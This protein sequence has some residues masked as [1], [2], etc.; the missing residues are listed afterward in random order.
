HTSAAEESHQSLDNSAA[1]APAQSNDHAAANDQGPA[2]DAPAAGPVAPAVAMV[3]AE[4]LQAAGLDGNAQ[5][6]GAVEK[7]V[8]EALGQG[9]GHGAAIDAILD[10]FHGGN[11]GGQAIANLASG[12]AN[13]VSAWD[14]AS[15]GGSSG[16]SEMLM[17]VGAEMLH[18]D[19]VLP[20]HNG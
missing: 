1:T 14:M 18:H 8:A 17:K 5:H 2:A 6:S 3:S 16:G 15:G 19:M 9:N 11:G 7:I 12:G 13:A 20:T 10:A 4:A